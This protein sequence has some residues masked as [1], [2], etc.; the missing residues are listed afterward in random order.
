MS[1]LREAAMAVMDPMVT[2]MEDTITGG[3]GTDTLSGSLARLTIWWDP[4]P[5]YYPYPYYPYRPRFYIEQQ[6]Q[7]YIERQPYYWYY[8]PD[9]R[10]YYPYAQT[11]PSSWQRVVPNPSQQ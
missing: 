9:S 8:C 1:P 11:C 10:T 6:A 4:W 5:Y 7:T 2:P 3:T